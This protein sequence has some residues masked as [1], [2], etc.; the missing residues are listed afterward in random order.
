MGV[1]LAQVQRRRQCVIRERVVSPLL[2][3]LLTGGITGAVLVLHRM[4]QCKR[5]SDAMLDAYARLLAEA[6]AEREKQGAAGDARKAPQPDGDATEQ[7]V[8]TLQLQSPDEL[9][10]ALMET[11]DQ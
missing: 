3:I 7:A 5:D 6:R 1:R 2:I 8:Q 4:A 11:L 10:G 9:A